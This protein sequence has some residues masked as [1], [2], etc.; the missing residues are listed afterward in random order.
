M[1]LFFGCPSVQRGVASPGAAIM[2]LPVLD[3]PVSDATMDDSEL[4]HHARSGNGG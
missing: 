2:A 3:N 4:Q 1:R